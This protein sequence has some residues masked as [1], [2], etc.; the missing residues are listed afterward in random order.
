[1][2]RRF[3]GRVSRVQTSR[4]KTS[5][6]LGPAT[7][8]NGSALNITGTGKTVGGVG[9]ESLADGLTLVR[10]RGSLLLYLTSTA[11]Q[12]NGFFGAFGI[13]VVT[14]Q[15]FAAGAASMPGPL[16]DVDWDGWFYHQFIFLRGTMLTPS[17]NLDRLAQGPEALRVDV[18]SKSMRKIPENMVVFIIL[19]ATESGTATMQW[20]YNSRELVKLP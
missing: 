6:T 17:Q 19:E 18:D 12:N 13:G 8:T 10:H 20:S 7:G 16:A 4:R 11:A 5:W 9:V 2:A 3:V 1:M 15:A 14:A